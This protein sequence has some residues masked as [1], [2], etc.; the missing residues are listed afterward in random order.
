MAEVPVVGTVAELERLLFGPVVGPD[1]SLVGS[2]LRPDAG[3]I[4]A[5]PRGEADALVDWCVSAGGPVVRLVCG[6]GGQG[7]THLA[8]QV[9]RRLWEQGWSAGVVSVPSPS[10]RAVRLSD[11]AQG[12]AAGQRARRDLQRVVELTAG[13]QAAVR[14][15]VRTLLVVDY[16]ENVGPVVAELLDT[17]AEA[18][19]A[20]C[21]RVLLLAR[22]DADWFR[23]LSVDHRL[24][25][26]VHPRPMRLATLSRDWD[27]GREWEVWTRAVQRFAVHARERGFEVPPGVGQASLLGGGFATTLDL[28]AGALLT[29]LDAADGP[30]GGDPGDLDALVGVLRHE[31]R[32]VSAALNAVGLDLG[33]VGQAWAVAMVSLT[34]P[35][36]VDEAMQVVSRLSGVSGVGDV[37]GHGLVRVLCGLFPDE[38]R[39]RV[40]QAPKPD[41]LTD[42]HLLELAARSS[43]RRQWIDD[44]AAVCGD[45]DPEVAAH[46]T[47]VL[48]RC[49]STPD[50][51]GVWR[52]GLGLVRD[53][54]A[55]LAVRFPPAYVPALVV[56]DPVGF[57][58][59]LVA[60]VNGSDGGLSLAQVEELDALLHRLG[61]ATTRTQVA[62]A[63]GQRLVAA[64]RTD[65]A[66]DE[67][68]QDRYARALN[69]LSVRLGEVGRRDE[70]LTA[71]EEAVTI[72]RRLA[73]TNPAGYLPDLAMSLNNLS[74]RLGEVG[75]HDEGLTAIE[76][77]VTIRRR[78]AETNPAGYLPDLAMSLNNLS[79][80]LGEVGRRDEALTAIEEAVTIRRRLAE[81]NPA[82]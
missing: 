53:G 62:V 67:V 45:D 70:G 58:S 77:A 26:W 63:V 33:E 57:E 2:W 17:I 55:G 75:R 24:H 23:A 29:V 4:Q 71:I 5:E 9:C 69:N 56:V 73:E 20:R 47:A 41:R 32:Q 50:P 43:S 74:V 21:V 8:G 49:L 14:L 72:R 22:T 35:G 65:A 59:E 19:A 48:R 10:W 68:S 81:T 79:V 16:A 46:A 31:Q 64:T 78:L 15:R 36:T 60:A 38:S 39:E 30:R 25:D 37:D 80:D 3:V 82:G 52:D 34:A 51:G 42:I 54:L 11:L 1:L 13:V 76:E 61:F 27:Q 66:R 44:L 40:W 6:S 7:K 18:D 12:G 28:Y